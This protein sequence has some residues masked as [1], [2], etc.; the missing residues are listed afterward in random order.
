LVESFSGRDVGIYFWLDIT[1]ALKSCK[2]CSRLKQRSFAW[3]ASRSAAT[4]MRLAARVSLRDDLPDNQVANPPH[5]TPIPMQAK[6]KANNCT[7]CLMG[8]GQISISTSERF[9]KQKIVISI[10]QQ[11]EINHITVFLRLRNTIALFFYKQH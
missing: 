11:T 8:K 2:S 6:S 9:A 7:S 1:R 3:R 4:T 5:K 10:A